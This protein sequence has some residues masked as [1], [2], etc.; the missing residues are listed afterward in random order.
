MSGH[1]PLRMCM[2]CREM[3]PKSELIRMVKTNGEVAIDTG[4]RIQSRGAYVCKSCK[5]ISLLK[6]KKC[7]ER[8][9]GGGS[10]DKVYADLMK[11]VE[12]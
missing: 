8:F 12:N 4:F 5:C 6:K 10:S 11:Y 2:A 7:I 3:K 1:I 9:F